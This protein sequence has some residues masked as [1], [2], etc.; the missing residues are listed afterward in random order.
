MSASLPENRELDRLL[1]RVLDGLH[2]DRDARRLNEILRSDIDACRRYVAYVELHGRLSWGDGVRSETPPVISLPPLSPLHSPLSPFFVGGPVFSYMVATVVL[3]LMLLGAWAYK[4]NYERNIFTADNRSSTTSGPLERQQLVFIGRV[5]GMKD[6]RW[7]DPDTHT[8]VGASVPLDREYAL[9]L[10]LM[11]ITYQSGAKVILEGPCTY[12]VESSAGGFL[13]RGKLTAN[14]RPQSSKLKAQSLDFSSLS[15]HHSPLFVVRTPTAVVTDLGTEFGVAVDKNGNTTTRVF[16]GSVRVVAAGD[17]VA[18]GGARGVVLRKNE[19][20]LVERTNSSDIL[21]KIVMGVAA[22]D[23]VKF[24]R[25]LPQPRRNFIDLADIAAGGDGLGWRNQRGVDP[26]TGAIIA[27]PI[28]SFG[29]EGDGRYHLVEGLPLVDGVFVPDG[30]QGP[31]QLDSAG[32]VFAGFPET[33]NFTWGYIWAGKYPTVK[34]TIPS[35]S[36][37]LDGV[38]YSGIPHSVLCMP[39]CKGVT[40]DIDAIRKM[41]PGAALR[42]FS[43]AAGNTEPRTYEHVPLRKRV[44]A[45]VWVF[46]DG[47]LRFS[48]TDFNSEDGA[49]PIIVPLQPTDR[50]LTLATTDAGNSGECDWTMFGDPRLEI[51]EK[52]TDRKE[53]PSR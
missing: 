37:W 4:I 1:D 52:I 38:D 12:K 44:S 7:S 17:V 20:A 8:I 14:I 29:A 25:E 43:A 48:K 28:G 53:E 32:H 16:Q 40:F 35:P 41:N 50:F 3:C 31:V 47:K 49:I 19:S 11:E 42:R 15:T 46:V 30:R 39:A 10:G 22:A 18:T 27:A 9:A 26:S 5:T 51:S 45:D 24:I 2:T 33:D 23:T 34:N 36:C 6:C 21:P 13:E